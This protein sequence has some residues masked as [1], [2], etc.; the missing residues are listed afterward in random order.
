MA[1]AEIAKKD[2]EI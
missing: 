1:T 2:A